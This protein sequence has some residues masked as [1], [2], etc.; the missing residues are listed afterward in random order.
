MVERAQVGGL[1]AQVHLAQHRG[2][3]RHPAH[4]Q[5]GRQDLGEGREVDH[6]PR[7]GVELPEAG[8]RIALEA[9]LPVGV[10]LHDQQLVAMRDLDQALAALERHRHAAG[11]VEVGDG[12]EQLGGTALGGQPGERLLHE[13]HPQPVLVHR[14]VLDAGLVGGEAGHGARVRRP[15]GEN[16]VARVHERAD[17]EVDRLLAAAGDHDVVH[18]GAGLLC[19]MMSAISS[20]SSARPS[21]GPFG[22]PRS[23]DRGRSPP[24]RRRRS[25]AGMT[26]CWGNPPRAR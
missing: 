21:V 19:P 1:L 24:R 10:V 18:P 8:Q 6:P 5:A 12:V 22:A 15:L 25:R 2:R 20:R 9:D 17:G 23:G 11:V 3:R 16:R 4:A 7:A 26:R 14:D 13:I